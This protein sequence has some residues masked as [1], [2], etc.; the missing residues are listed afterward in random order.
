M[1]RQEVQSILDMVKET[2]SLIEEVIPK[3]ISI[4]FAEVL[5]NLLKEGIP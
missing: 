2:N 4:G 5:A 3:L 1:G